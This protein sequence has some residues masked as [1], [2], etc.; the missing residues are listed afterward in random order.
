MIYVYELLML[1]L[2]YLS[3]RDYDNSLLARLLSVPVNYNYAEI[4]KSHN[5]AVGYSELEV[6]Q[7]KVINEALLL[8]YLLN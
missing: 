5:I 4:I 1:M 6:M 7:E 8:D 3:L 2:F